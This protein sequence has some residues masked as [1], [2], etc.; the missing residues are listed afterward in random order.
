M[1]YNIQVIFGI[2]LIIACHA[3]HG[4]S[5]D[6]PTANTEIT[7]LDLQDASVWSDDF[8]S[9]DLVGV[10]GWSS[11]VLLDGSRDAG[12]PTYHGPFT[13]PG[14]TTLHRYFNIESYSQVSISLD[15]IWSCEPQPLTDYFSVTLGASTSSEWSFGYPDD[16]PSIELISD[17]AITNR[18]P[19]NDAK[20]WRKSITYSAIT[21]P[22]P[23]YFVEITSHS[24]SEEHA[25]ITNIQMQLE[26]LCDLSAFN[27]TAEIIAHY[28]QSV[29]IGDECKNS[30]RNEEHEAIISALEDKYQI[31]ITK[32]RDTDNIYEGNY[33]GIAP[34]T[35]QDVASDVLQIASEDREIIADILDTELTNILPSSD[36]ESTEEE[37]SVVCPQLNSIYTNI[38][39]L[40]RR[41]MMGIDPTNNEDGAVFI[42]RDN[43][44]SYTNRIGTDESNDG[45]FAIEI[46]DSHVQIPYDMIN[47]GREEWR[48]EKM[49]SVDISV[50][51][52]DN[53]LL[54]DC[55]GMMHDGEGDQLA[56]S[57]D[58]AVDSTAAN[59]PFTLSFPYSEENSHRVCAW[60][61]NEDQ[62]E[63]EYDG[64][65]TTVTE[66]AIICQ[67]NHR[68]VFSLIEDLRLN[69]DA[70]TNAKSLHVSGV[71]IG[72]LV[73]YS[74]LALAATYLVITLYRIKDMKSLAFVIVSVITAQ[75]YC[76]VIQYIYLSFAELQRIPLGVTYCVISLPL[77]CHF[78]VCSLLILHWMKIFECA[79]T[80]T[81]N[82]RTLDIAIVW[83]NVLISVV[84]IAL[85][86]ASMSVEEET[87]PIIISASNGV[88][89]SVCILICTAWFYFGWKTSTILIK[90]A[91]AVKDSCAGALSEALTL[92]RRLLRLTFVIGFCFFTQSIVAILSII[93][94][95]QLFGDN[96]VNFATIWAICDVVIFVTFILFYR[97][98]VLRQKQVYM[99][100]QKAR[101]LEREAR[102]SRR[103]NTFTNGAH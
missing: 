10:T 84:F 79:K 91:D 22:N 8:A 29:D 15:F 54:N 30:L 49:D 66:D 101:E 99:M 76:H 1:S 13:S 92:R 42:E 24:T 68:T 11:S 55:N 2:A 41:M 25:L 40:Q 28:A 46:G 80:F 100:E 97:L 56:L 82:N 67:C 64:C 33:F 18:C 98:Y 95:L 5:K 45:I 71:Y 12:H 102:R 7:S 48:A 39:L 23:E 34:L 9:E 52:V 38:A 90:S 3:G 72:F 74:L 36:T 93:E 87:L 94:H 21:A 96:F 85:L 65:D 53:V 37:L 103:D 20:A 32:T 86:V 43:F 6:Q 62:E 59:V 83:M 47:T 69:R 31:Y 35:P 88:L 19:Q 77:L 75:I 73:V 57:I 61:E 70:A 4:K 58:I 81:A 14:S 89:G 26:P 51:C 16:D 60:V 27:P 50:M 78:W 44:C 63:W 17:T